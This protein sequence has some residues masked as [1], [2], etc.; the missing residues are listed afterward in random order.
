MITDRRRRVRPALPR[1][2]QQQHHR[3][4]QQYGNTLVQ[5]GLSQRY[6]TVQLAPGYPASA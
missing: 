3:V 5:V 2:S 4:P 1:E 6:F